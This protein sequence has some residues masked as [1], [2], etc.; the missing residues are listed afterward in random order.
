M[1]GLFDKFPN[2][3]LLLAHSGG[4][5][6]FLAGRLDSCVVHDP[7]CASRLKHPPSTYLKKL[8][9]DAVCYSPDALRCLLSFTDA[10]NILFG[11]DNPFFPPLKPGKEIHEKPWK[12]VVDNVAAINMV[13][14]E[15]DKKLILSGN[16]ERILGL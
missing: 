13:C 4:A 16:C 3:K 5:L 12:S 2:L 15:K 9:Y 6:P 11:T 14:D 10:R 7:A 8:Y 1:L